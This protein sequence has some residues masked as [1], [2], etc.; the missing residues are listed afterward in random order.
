MTFALVRPSDTTA[1]LGKGGGLL[2]FGGLHGIAVVL[3]TRRDAGFPS[4]SFVGIATGTAGSG[5]SAHL[6]FRATSTA[7]PNLR[8]GT[9]LIGIA[10]TGTGSTRSITVGVDGKQYL[11]TTVPLPASVLP[12]FTAGTGATTAELNQVSGVSLRSAA[13]SVPPPGGGWSYNGSAQVSGTGFDTDLTTALANQAGTVI[14]PRAVATTATSSLTVHFEFQV[15][16]G[17]GAN[18]LTF[19]L[20]SPK[21]AATA[22]GGTGPGLGV[23]GLSGMAA[24][25]ATSGPRHG[26]QQFLRDRHAERDER[27]VGVHRAR[28]GHGAP[29]RDSHGGTDLERRQDRGVPRRRGGGERARPH[30]GNLAAGL[31]GKHR[32]PDRRPRDPGR[33]RRRQRLVR[34]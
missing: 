11:K 26:V 21:T 33:L 5:A 31:L 34:C 9:H 8:K 3:G 14:Y 20:L 4:A 29:L 23:S 16:G 24:T 10:V 15:G 28:P 1:A 19:D 6:V 32:H 2:G 25:F 22:V 17:T 13:G 7:G 30:P 18:A 27:A 12:A